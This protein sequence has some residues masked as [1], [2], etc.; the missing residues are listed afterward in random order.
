MALKTKMASLE[1]FRAKTQLKHYSKR[2]KTA[3][4]QKKIWFRIVARK[5]TILTQFRKQFLQSKGITSIQLL[6]FKIY[7]LT[8]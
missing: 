1:F 7:D 5:A 2:S 6:N 8:C 4:I 3:R